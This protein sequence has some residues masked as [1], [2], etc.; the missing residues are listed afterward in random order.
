M[1]RSMLRLLIFG[2]LLITACAPRVTPRLQQE[3]IEGAGTRANYEA[4]AERYAQEAKRLSEQ[5]EQRRNLCEQYEGSV[6]YGKLKEVVVRHCQAKV[7]GYQEATD[8]AL[9]LARRHREMAAEAK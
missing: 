3:A 6:V 1:N 4:L 2:V 5:A 7:G 9:A 8:E